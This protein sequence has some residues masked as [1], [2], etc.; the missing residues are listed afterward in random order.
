MFGDSYA[1]LWKKVNAAEEKDLPKTEYDL[2]QKIV[3]KASKNRDYGQLLKA[4]LQSA[5]VMASIAPD[6][7][8]PSIEEMKKT[9]EQSDDEVLRTV[10]QTV[11]WRIDRNNYSLS[12]DV[13]QPELTAELC[14][15]LA[16]VKDKDYAPFVIE[17]IDASIFDHDL[18]HVVGYELNAGFEEMLKYY[19]KVGNRR[20]A[21]IV[22]SKVYWYSNNEK[23]DPVI[24]EY[25]D[26][27]EAGELALLHYH[28]IAYDAKAEKMAYIKE[29]LGKWG[30]W[31][32][33]ATLRNE[34]ATLT[35]PQFRVAYDLEVSL[36]GQA[37]EV[38]L[39]DVR[40]L[41][42]VTMKVYKVKAGGDYTESPNY[43][44]GYEKIKPLLDG[45][46][47]EQTRQY[48]GKQPYE[49]FEDVMTRFETDGL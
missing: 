46:V 36:P 31:K 47:Y 33:L 3:K 9:Y 27:P 42:S 22:A 21:C 17:G 14:E 7:L 30:S 39:A 10:W 26:L 4:G 38:R 25:E 40:N 23:L 45:V 12:L 49:L 48:D 43:N 15:K 24:R 29:A 8:Q 16:Q 32:R 28:N 20:A 41:S 6:S 34:R 19:K 44:K 1:S 35:N 2:L 5:Q 13:K 18:L 11:L 37:Q